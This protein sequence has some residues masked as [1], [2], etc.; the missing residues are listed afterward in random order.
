MPHPPLVA[1]GTAV[2]GA[3]RPGEIGP[4]GPYGSNEEADAPP[5]LTSTGREVHENDGK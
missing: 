2:L 1:K 3:S 4:F 5:V